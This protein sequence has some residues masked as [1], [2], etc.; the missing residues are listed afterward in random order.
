MRKLDRIQTFLKTRPRSEIIYRHACEGLIVPAWY[1]ESCPENER[2]A[3]RQIYIRFQLDGSKEHPQTVVKK[4]AD[5]L[6][7]DRNVVFRMWS[8]L[9]DMM[10]CTQT[11]NEYTRFD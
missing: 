5:D 1:R 11:G 4:I 7:M 10:A 8:T 6:G 9:G 2:E 3:L